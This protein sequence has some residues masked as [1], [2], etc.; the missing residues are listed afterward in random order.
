MDNFTKPCY[1]VRSETYAPLL[2]PSGPGANSSQ[3]EYKWSFLESYLIYLLVLIPYDR[4]SKSIELGCTYSA[5][6]LWQTFQVNFTHGLFWR[7]VI[8]AFRQ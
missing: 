7:G 1:T 2:F 5:P 3:Y 6:T 8:C 4:S